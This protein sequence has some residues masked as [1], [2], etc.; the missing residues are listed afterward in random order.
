M[1][2][3]MCGSCHVF[4]AAWDPMFVFLYICLHGAQLWFSFEGTPQG[5][6]H[7][8]GNFVPNAPKSAQG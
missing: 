3:N 6:G 1:P 4:I 5:G 7:R 8:E 2:K